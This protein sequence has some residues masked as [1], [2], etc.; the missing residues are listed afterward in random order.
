MKSDFAPQK[1]DILY[2]GFQITRFIC[3]YS[4]K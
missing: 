2:I 4:Y 1:Y 3:V